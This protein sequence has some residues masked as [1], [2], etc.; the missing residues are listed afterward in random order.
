MTLL[1]MCQDIANEL[2]YES[3]SSV[4]GNSDEVARRLLG[5]AQRSGK[6]LAVGRVYNGR[7][8]MVGTHDWTALTKEQTF[9]TD[10]TSSYELTSSGIITDNDFLRFVDNTWWDRTNDRPLVLVDKVTWQRYVSGTIT[11]GINKL[12][13]KRGKNLVVHPTETSGETWV[14]EYVSNK[15]CESSGGTEQSAW[16]ADT[17]V[18]LLD[19]NL[20]TLDIKWRFL[21]SMGQP[22]AVQQ[23]EFYEELAAVAG[24]DGGKDTIDTMMPRVDEAL[25]YNFPETG[26]GQ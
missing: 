18:A 14:F 13:M 7:G 15:W 12:I 25:Y 23:S 10:G 9:T 8:Q 4:V 19:E 24:E 1:S 5:A 20:M 17:D 16:A 3:I 22:Y 26:Y 21:E 2:G 11:L 6:T